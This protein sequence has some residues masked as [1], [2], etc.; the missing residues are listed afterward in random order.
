MAFRKLRVYDS[1][2]NT[3][4]EADIGALSNNIL[5]SDDNTKTLDD[6][7]TEI[8][9]SFSGTDGTDAGLGGMV[10]APTEEQVNKFLKSDGT[11]ADVPMDVTSVNNKTGAV[12]LESDDVGAIAATTKGSANGVAELDANGKVPSSQLPSYVDDVIEGYINPVDSKFYSTKTVSYN[13]VTPE[14]TEN[15]SNENWYELNTNNEYVFSEDTTVINEKDYFE[16]NVTYSDKLSDEASK[17]YI[18]L[19]ANQCYRWGGTV[20]VAMASSLA[21]GETNS[22][23]YRGDRGKA[24]YDHS[25]DFGK[26]STATAAGLY[27]VGSTA[28]GHISDLSPITKSDITNLG[29]PAQDTT[30]TFG[31]GSVNEVSN[32][33]QGTHTNFTINGD[34]LVITTGTLPSLTTASQTVLTSAT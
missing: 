21:L 33:Q 3:Y 32:F 28:E 8:E 2:T 11:W 24:A 1:S 18:D 30:Y 10:P 29:I 7:L 27:K 17:I 4:T 5:M 15:P 25:Q 20:Y 23:A 9:R 19:D 31:S 14:G 26:V 16:K 22:T 6:K 12:I 13:T 34:T